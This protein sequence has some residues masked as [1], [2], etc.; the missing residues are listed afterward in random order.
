MN[1]ITT[2]IF[3]FLLFFFSVIIT[4]AQT[5]NSQRFN[6]GEGSFEY[7]GYEPLK[8]KSVTVFYYTPTKGDITKMPV[9]FSFHGAERSGKIQLN[10]WKYFAEQYGFIVIAPEFSKTY[11]SENDYQF[12]GV[13]TSKDFK[14]LQ[15]EEKWTGKVVESLFDFFRAETKSTA[16]TYN[17]FGH[18]AG[19][20][21]V[22]RFLMAMPYARVNK[23]V[24]ANAGSWTFP[25]PEGIVG[26][27]GEAY[28]W[29]MSVMGTPFTK[30]STLSNFYSKKLFIQL[31]QLDTDVNDPNLPKTPP[32]LAQGRYRLERG[33]FFY[34][35]C[36]KLARNAGVKFGF[37]KAEVADAG[38]ST[39]RMV[40]GRA[41]PDRKDISNTGQN[42]AFDLLFK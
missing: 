36:K 7:N 39:L 20:Q 9:L 38:H 19:A 35:E 2:A 32:A 28:G 13:F 8:D 34:E 27:D 29:P 30:E 41:V 33:R 1:K 12:G 24:A 10:A 26:A 15:K 17:M 11:F 42:C 23:A 21:F 3:T 31:G 16:S 40:Y 25:Y 14:T 4:F 6:R 18:S 37:Q 5:E 22:H